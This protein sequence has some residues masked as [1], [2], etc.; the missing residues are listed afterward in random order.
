[1]KKFIL[2]LLI[3]LPSINNIT[4]QLRL[5]NRNNFFE[6]ES[7]MLFEE[8]R[9]ALPLYQQLL[10]IDPDNANYKYRIG[11]CYLNI[12]G[13][14]DKA[15]SYLED[16][17]KN[18]NQRYREGNFNEKSAPPDALFYLGYAY[19]VN[20]QLDKAIEAY[21][22]FKRSMNNRIYD[23]T[24][25]N[26]QIQSCYN[27]KELMSK[28]QYI[29]M[30]NLGGAI[31]SSNSEFNPVV[32][33][34]EDII[35]F[36]RR[37][38]FYDAILYSTKVNGQWTVP[39]N[40]NEMLRVDRD[41]YPTSLSA[42][43]KTLY[44]YSSANYDG[45]I[46]T[47]KFENGK[48]MPIVK[49]NSNINTR[50]WESH[51]TV[52]HDDQKLYFTSNRGGTHGGLDIYVSTRNSAGDWGVA[53]NLG[54]VINTPYNEE[55]PFLSKD[56]KTL[57][58]S[59]RGHYNMGGYDVF[60]SKLLDNG[61]WSEP[62]NLGY[63]VNTTDDD[64]FFKPINDGYVAY[65]SVNRPE[66]FGKEDI[67][68]I[69][70]F[71]DNNPRK[72]FVNGTVIDS[73]DNKEAVKISFAKTDDSK[74][75]Q[76]V[77]SDPI[78][79]RFEVK[80]LPHGNYNVTFETQD[81][82]KTVRNLNLPIDMESDTVMLSPTIIS[83]GNTTGRPD[84]ETDRN[85]NTVATG[86]IADLSI[87]RPDYSRVISANQIPYFVGTQEELSTAEKSDLIE[88][89]ETEEDDV[90]SLKDEEPQWFIDEKS[91]KLWALWLGI[92]VVVLFF[93]IFFFRRNRKEK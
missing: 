24:I 90:I 29:R 4:A 88:N 40:M 78:T 25:V 16:A 49:L 12:S 85:N 53:T 69:E 54:P 10:R 68:R 84:T 28:P 74:I 13:E 2:I 50:Y 82:E 46:Y 63:P 62:V 47:S 92:G 59:S 30:Q 6:A 8:Y 43:G 61:A 9:D 23:S 86:A 11:Q 26:L 72:F 93:M 3:F 57:F 44:L 55:S 71:N 45:D 27:A 60:Y 21:R 76:Q 5:E 41:L 91:C 32:S 67:Y 42:D 20:N 73:E 75:I 34:N 64:V 17:V 33:D 52:S 87:I 51:A 19:R 81:G 36:M 37:E 1:M 35:V 66:G 89:P 70:I 83:R 22:L 31:N 38:A 79:G 58:F 39:Q 18:I 77:S 65:Y 80:D 48:W 7:W 14:K 56:G 15:I